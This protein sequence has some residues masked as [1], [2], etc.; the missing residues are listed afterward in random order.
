MRRQLGEHVLSVLLV[1]MVFFLLAAWLRHQDASRR[2]VDIGLI[3]PFVALDSIDFGNPLHRALFKETL[4]SFR[5]DLAGKADSL[6]GAIDRYRQQRFSE[7]MYK[8]GVEGTR[9]TWD[10]AGSLA[11]MYLQFIAVYALVMVVSYGAA[12]A[13]AL[14]RFIRMK[15]RRESD[16]AACI[17]ALRVQA[18]GR[19]IRHAM[20][21]I[22]R[23][24]SYVVL[25]S[26]A[27]VI[28]Y[29]I[30]T[31]IDTDS[32][33][34]MIILGVLSNGL[35]VTYANKFYSL[36]VAESR[37]G[38]VETALAK[39][40]HASYRWQT[41]DGVPYRAIVTPRRSI[42]GH[43]MCHIYQNARFQF[44]PTLKQH[45]SFLISGLI[46]IE[47]ALNIQGRL[48]YE[49]LQDLLYERYEIALSIILGIFFIVKATEVVVDVLHHR[50]GL[51]YENRPA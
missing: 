34:F 39:N 23:G 38:Y 13:L 22:A 19:A 4:N 20:Q 3:A 48:C 16:V 42:N 10:R 6:L 18:G 33:L 15:Q 5:P 27:Y 35:L 1:G 7:R 29:S 14:Q 45:A 40:L 21:A 43:V 9:L 26:P 2:A 36:L 25:F 17:A 28:A 24:A 30:K 8:T 12:R 46:I 11:G 31:R 32:L 49:L 44:L 47:M 41:P 50:E 51:R 37:K